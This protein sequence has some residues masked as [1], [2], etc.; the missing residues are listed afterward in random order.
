MDQPLTTVLGQR[1]RP[2][3]AWRKLR[4]VLLANTGIALFLT[5]IDF[6]DG[7]AV[8]WL[9]AL[10]NFIFSQ[11]I[12]LTIYFLA[13]VCSFIETWR[14]YKQGLGLFA[15]GGFLGTLI[16]AGLIWGLFDICLSGRS[17]AYSAAPGRRDRAAGQPAR[18]GTV[19]L[20]E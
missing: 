8:Y 2:A 14:P 12:G 5:L 17:R 18:P 4:P 20:V 15:L 1:L 13:A 10:V 9:E 11:S 16:A 7:G 6:E 3:I 19:G